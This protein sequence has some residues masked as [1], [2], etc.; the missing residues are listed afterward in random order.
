M[1]YDEDGDGSEENIQEAAT[2][3]IQEQNA[4]EDFGDD[5]DDFEAGAGDDDFGDFDEGFP[6]PEVQQEKSEPQRPP[7]PVPESPFVSSFTTPQYKT[8]IHIIPSTLRL[9]LQLNAS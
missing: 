9:R 6:E 5:F 1:H 3:S 4:N 8:Q 7:A 2:D